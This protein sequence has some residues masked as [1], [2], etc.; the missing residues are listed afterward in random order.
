MMNT[1]NNTIQ[2]TDLSSILVSIYVLSIY[3]MYHINSHILSLLCSQQRLIMCQSD[4]SHDWR[5][6]ACW[7]EGI[8]CRDGKM[9]KIIYALLSG[10]WLIDCDYWCDTNNDDDDDDDDIGAVKWRWVIECDCWC[11]AVTYLP[12]EMK[13]S[14]SNLGDTGLSACITLTVIVEEEITHT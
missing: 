6:L 4:P 12:L 11:D 14:Q 3:H 7:F 10:G 13:K 2:L 9:I 5:T 1:H 8:S